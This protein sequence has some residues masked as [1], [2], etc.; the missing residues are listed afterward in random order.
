MAST[1]YGG[2]FALIEKNLIGAQDDVRPFL[3][4]RIGDRSV[5]LSPQA[6]REALYR[7]GHDEALRT[8]L[9]RQAIIEARR[10]PRG[11]NGPGRLL[12]VWLAIPGVYRNLYRIVH[13][14]R[15]ERID[16]E[17][18]AALAVLAALEVVDPDTPDPG[19]PLVK[20]AVNR[21]WAYANRVVREIPHVDIAAFAEARNATSLPEQQPCPADGWELH[22]T[23]PPRRDE[24]AATLRF[25]ESRTRQEGERL[26]A[27][28]HRLGLPDLVYR[29]RRHEEADLIGTLVLRPAGARQ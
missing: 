11:G 14:L 17:S 4:V 24:L 26:G 13:R 7:P 2:V 15:V 12:L 8:V 21:M 5:R 28:A 1:E 18:E 16:L 19:G 22:L 25:A 6:A 10:E 29:A 23:P 20:E 27:L 3:V 9:W